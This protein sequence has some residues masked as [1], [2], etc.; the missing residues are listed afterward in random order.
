MARNTHTHWTVTTTSLFTAERNDCT[1]RAPTQRNASLA[2]VQLQSFTHNRTY[3]R[4]YLTR[5]VP[6]PPQGA[7]VQVVGE[8]TQLHLR[9]AQGWVRQWVP[10]TGRLHIALAQ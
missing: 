10:S 3:D 6:L 8:A 7:V 5:S 2:L 4:T 9:Q 1:E